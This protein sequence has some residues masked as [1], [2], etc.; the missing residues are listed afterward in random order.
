MAQLVSYT[1]PS[2]I[3]GV[4]QQPDPQRD[5]TQ[6]EIQIN[7]VSSVAEGLRKRDSTHTLA[8]VSETRFGDAFIHTI[9][10]DNT[11][12]YLAV[13]ANSSIRVF[14]LQG[15]ERP[16]IAP[17]G[18]DYL[19]TATDCKR[20]LRAVTIADYT[21]IT[22][23]LVAPAMD[24]LLSPSPSRPTPHEA[25]V[26]VKAANYGQEYKLNIN[27][28]EVKVETPVSPVTSSGTT[29]TENRIS[30]AEVAEALMLGLQGK[31]TGITQITSLAPITAKVTA[32]SALTLRT[33]VKFQGPIKTLNFITGKTARL[34]VKTYENIA[35]TTSGPGL[36]ATIAITVVAIDGPN[37]ISAIALQKPG[38]GYNPGDNLAFNAYNLSLDS[39]VPTELVIATIG[40]IVGGSGTGIPTTTSGL[41]RG[42]TVDVTVDDNG[43]VSLLRINNPGSGYALGDTIYVSPSDIIPGSI[44]LRVAVGTV[45]EMADQTAAGAQI[46]NI[47]VY[48]TAGSGA[49]VDLI[50]KNGRITTVTLNQAGDGYVVGQTLSVEPKAIDESS[51]LSSRIDVATVAALKPAV[52]GVNGVQVQ[53]S[54]SVLWLRSPSPIRIAATDARANADITAILSTA[55]AFTDLPTI[56]PAGYLLEISGDPGTQFDGYYVQFKPRSG[57]FGEGEWIETVAPGIE[58]RIAPETMPHLLVRM[59]DGSFLFSRANGFSSGGLTLPKWG[60]RTSGDYETSPDPS[61]IGSPINDI[62]VFKGRLGFLADE[63]VILS[64][65]REFFEFFPETVT[66]V[67]DTDPIDV[68]ASNN[69]VSVLRYAIPYQDELILFSPQYQFRFSSGDLALT[70]ATA[71]ITALTQ[72]EVDVT[73][74]PQQAGGGIIFCQSNAQ[75]TQMR[76]FSVRGAGTALTADAQ[77]LTGY[78]S[79]YIPSQVFKMTVNDTGNSL[80]AIS[81]KAGYQ[82]RI[83]TY[84]WFFRNSG[85]GAERAQSSWSY[86]EFNGVDEVLQVACIQEALYCLM[87]YGEEVYLEMV[88]VMDRMAPLVEGPYPLLLD[89][90]V[91]TTTATSAPMRMAKGV[92]D[93]ALK[94]T[95][96]TLPYPIKAKTQ[97]WSGYSYTPGAKPGAVLL[98]EASSGTTI[99]ARGDWSTADVFAGEPYEFR[100]RFSRFKLMRDIGGGKAAASVTR[101]QV[102]QAKLR[103]HETGFFRVLVMPEHRQQLEYRYDGAVAATRGAVIGAATTYDPDAARH[104]EGVFNIPIMSKGERC[105]VELRNDSPHPCK[106][107]TCEWVAMAY[108]KA[109]SMQ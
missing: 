100:Y 50:I 52:G 108:G 42:M 67:L 16:V 57:D 75:W 101:T 9:L 64:R 81:E 88:P 104:Y 13:I 10:R 58:F 25:L 76:E 21:F 69:R 106:F 74:R 2:L 95:T 55:Q 19:S 5:P 103:Y 84:K 8:R 11:E 82:K 59:P 97:V 73:V 14:D 1:I 71:Q 15:N 3:Q 107:S 70:P 45:S 99:N 53:R 51:S 28:T 32:P 26:W 96:W 20:Q 49:T 30:A 77:D 24:P 85:Q 12:E 105:M 93:P 7:G 102:R 4:S 86:W 54:G 38:N 98:G 78:V 27:G 34:A 91:S 61:F 47:P 109:R 18:Y 87:R 68:I 39:S 63:S 23:T 36:G 22:N 37:L 79:S 83:Y 35:T 72:F 66:T 80:Y 48:A 43:N 60:E 46:K 41:G 56:A 40:S 62:F 89:R 65:T 17:G 29:Q 90:R 94:R 6:G 33:G 31:L 44:Q 92:Y